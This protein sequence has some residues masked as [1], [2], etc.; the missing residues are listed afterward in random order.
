M[1]K[2]PK[3]YWNFFSKEHWMKEEYSI[4][5]DFLNII[6]NVLEHVKETQKEMTSLSKLPVLAMESLQSVHN[7]DEMLYWLQMQD[8]A[9]QQLNALIMMLEGMKQSIDVH[10]SK[11]SEDALYTQ[12]LIEQLDRLLK[13]A[14]LQKKALKGNSS[15]QEDAHKEIDFF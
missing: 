2:Q 14:Q 6:A 12:T 1:L 11:K 8:I 13:A 7:N 5:N 15:T 10:L 3:I 4:L 9:E